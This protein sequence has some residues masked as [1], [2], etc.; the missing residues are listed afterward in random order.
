M[1]RSLVPIFFLFF[2]T[3][4]AQTPPLPT[5]ESRFLNGFVKEIAGEQIDYHSFHPYATAALLTRCLDG[6]R[7]ISWQTE[8][9]PP[10][11][12]D[13]FVTFIW[14]AGHSTGTSSADAT[15]HVAI[16]GWPWFTFTTVKERRVKEWTV[17][18]K[19]GARLSFDARWE[20]TVNDL[21]GYVSMKVPVR[22]FPR[23]QPLL[24]SIVGDSAN[25][26]DWYMTFKYA[27]RESIAVQVQPALMRSAAGERQLVDVVIDHIAKSGSAD[28]SI[29]G[30]EPIKT[31]LSLGFNRVQFTVDPVAEPKQIDLTVAVSGWPEK[32][33]QITLHPVPYREFWLLPHSHNDIGYSDLQADVEKKQLKNLRD[34][35]Q[36]FRKTAGYPKEARFKWNTEILWAVERFLSTCTETERKEFIETVRQGGIGLNALYANQLT[37]I[38]RPEELFRLTDFARH[39]VKTYGVKISD[40]MVTDIP[41]FTWAMVPALAKGGIKYFSSGPNYIPSLND[42]GDRVGYYNRAWGDRPFYWVSPSGQEKILF[43]VAGKGYS[44]FH[45]WIAGKAGSSTATN[46]FDYLRELDEKQYPYDMV[47]LRYTIVADNGPTDPDLPDFVKSWNEKYVSPKLVIATASS[48]FEEFERRWGTSLPSFAGDITPYWEDGALSTLRELG[49]TRRASERLIQA[50]YLSCLT[51][52]NP[53]D[54]AKFAEA[55]RNVNLFD[56]H[57]WGAYNSVS[58]PDNPFAVSQWL[59]KQRYALDL[60]KQSSELLSDGLSSVQSGKGIDVLNSSSWERT[61]LIV[62]PKGQ[63][64]QGDLVVGATG[65]PVPSQRLSTGELAF[66]A[67]A[68]P[69]LGASRYY[70]RP[71]RAAGKGTVEVRGSELRNGLLSARIDPKTGA[72]SNLTLASGIQFVDSSKSPGLNQYL[73]VPGKNPA[74][75]L[76]GRVARIEI[77]ENGPL[78]GTLC[79]TLDAPGCRTLVQEIRVVDRLAQVEILNLLDKTKVRE[80]ESVHFAFPVS[81]PEGTFRLDGGWGI[82]RPTADQLPGSCKDYLSAGRWVDISNQDY[83]ITWT[84]V[85]SPLIEIG[86]MT[87]E[88][89]GPKGYRVWRTSYSPGTTFYSYAMDNYWHTNYTA[90]QEG[91]AALHFAVFPHGPFKSINAYRRGIEQNQPLLV[92]EVSGNKAPS[93]SLLTLTAPGIVATSL[94]P[95]EDGKAVMIRLFNA[96]GKPEEFRIRW[97]AFK[98][99]KVFF[100]S[101]YETRNGLVGDTLALP[102]YGIVTLRCER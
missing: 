100:S 87:D 91:A 31:G 38:C 26:R 65:K 40:A 55:W 11:Y 102:A 42:G 99:T 30:Q 67:E 79:V 37:G 49:L 43:W 62:L 56:E 17:E 4:C 53:P 15:F 2:S 89:L 80:K 66:L 12:T 90:D 44:W 98:P 54:R 34:A 84:T 20:D 60:D 46:L 88:T 32:R 61:G 97:G 14:I 24:V 83:G 92:R 19:D 58:D 6:K 36:L 81:V 22:D 78:V 74:N 73:Y 7:I 5:T 47:Q 82:L 76:P 94:M 29:P 16:D 96:G 41:G 101:L 57:T 85:E 9:I 1:Y 93:G 21:F 77:K 39:L 28:I 52:A 63:S 18:G 8:A 72:I 95:S 51:T 50:E 86:G 25:S 69:G 33:E 70:I 64:S 13:E 68:V 27:M 75:A 3:L 23:G 48:M 35:I 45:G 71:G 10:N 59:V